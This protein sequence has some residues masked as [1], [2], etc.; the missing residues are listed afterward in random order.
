M[1]ITI[2]LTVSNERFRLFRSQG[3]NV[4]ISRLRFENQSAAPRSAGKL[5]LGLA[6]LYVIVEI[7]H[8]S[9]SDDR[10]AFQ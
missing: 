6:H 8:S 7:K 1:L 10:R 4:L 9:L 2:Y 5:V 3:N